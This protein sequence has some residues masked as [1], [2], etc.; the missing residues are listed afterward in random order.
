MFIK[1]FKKPP[2]ANLD[3]HPKLD[4]R[5]FAVRTCEVT[6]GGQSSRHTILDINRWQGRRALRCNY[7][8]EMPVGPRLDYLTQPA[9]LHCGL[10]LL[11]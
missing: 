10:W 9:D 2:K 7:K 5:Q 4:Y 11:L 1:A 3:R 6:R 8:A